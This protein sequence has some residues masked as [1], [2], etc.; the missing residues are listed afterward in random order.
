MWIN[1][2][3]WIEFSPLCQTFVKIFFPCESLHSHAYQNSIHCEVTSRLCVH[4]SANKPCGCVC[5][6]IASKVSQLCHLFPSLFVFPEECI[7][8]ALPIYMYHTFFRTIFNRHFQNLFRI[9]IF[10]SYFV[11]LNICFV[12]KLLPRGFFFDCIYMYI[13]MYVY[14]KIS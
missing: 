6:A 9:L 2:K 3:N 11:G 5:L 12:D 4:V 8:I 14:F 13:Y 10:L 1:L 7:E